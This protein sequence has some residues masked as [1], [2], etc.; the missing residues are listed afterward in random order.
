MVYDGITF[1]EGLRRDVLRELKAVET[2]HPVFNSSTLDPVKADRKAVGSSDPSQ[3]ASDQ[4]WHQAGSSVI[5][6]SLCLRGK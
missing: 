2:M 1:D 6:V 3:C 4:A 5:L